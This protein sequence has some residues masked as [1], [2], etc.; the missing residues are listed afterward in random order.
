MAVRS[1][2]RQPLVTDRIHYQPSGS[3][4]ASRRPASDGDFSVSDCDIWLPRPDAFRRGKSR[5]PLIRPRSGILSFGLA[6]V[7][8]TFSP[9][10]LGLGFFEGACV[11]LLHSMGSDLEPAI[12]ATLIPRGFTLWL[13]TLPGLWFIRQETRSAIP[14]PQDTISSTMHAPRRRGGSRAS[15]PTMTKCSPCAE[16]SASGLRCTRTSPER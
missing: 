6:S 15:F 2:Q 1:R 5:W 16:R 4:P 7:A 3:S 8:A 14:P 12:A 9:V 13:P 11:G 10:P